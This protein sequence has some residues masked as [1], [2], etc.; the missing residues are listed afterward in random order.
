MLATSQNL[1]VCWICFSSGRVHFFASLPRVVEE[2]DGNDDLTQ[3]Y[4]YGNYIDEVLVMDRNEDEDDSAI[5]DGDERFHYHQDALYSVYAV[6]DENGDIEESYLY[7]PYGEV[8]VFDQN[9][10]EV[11]DNVWGTANSVIDNPQQFSFW[12]KEEY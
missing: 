6:T 12:E 11:D 4:V 1:A 9:G 7:E 8:T 5:G 2:R 10:V 3:Q